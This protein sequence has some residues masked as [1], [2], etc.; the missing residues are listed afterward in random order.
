MQL[1][2]S[3]SKGRHRVTSLD[4]VTAPGWQELQ[5]L[6]LYF[7]RDIEGCPGLPF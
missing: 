6:A 1:Y 2:V 3:D 7:A 4:R 5:L